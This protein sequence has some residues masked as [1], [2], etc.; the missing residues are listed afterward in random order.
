MRIKRRTPKSH[1]PITININ[2][3][4]IPQHPHPLHIARHLS[5]TTTTIDRPIV[6]Q[7]AERTHLECRVISVFFDE[8]GR[9]RDGDVGGDGE[10]EDVAGVGAGVVEERKSGLYL[11]VCSDTDE[12]DPV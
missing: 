9:G 7:C 3:D 2:T 8:C 5:T 10:Y 12:G 1:R 6:G 11:S 4:L